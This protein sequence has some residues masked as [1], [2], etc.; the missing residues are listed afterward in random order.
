MTPI[1]GF[2]R[3]SALRYLSGMLL[4]EVRRPAYSR[5]EIVSDAVVHA[6]GVGLAVLAVPALVTAAALTRGDLPAVLGVTVYGAALIAMLTFSALYNLIPHPDWSRILQR[7]DHSAIYVKIAGTFTAL[8]LLAGQHLWLIGVL[9]SAATAGVSLKLWAPHGFRRIGLGLYL[10]MGW[11]GAVLGWGVFAALPLGSVVLIAAGGGIYT[12][13]VL[14]YLWEKLPH[15]MAIWHVFVLLGSLA[16][17]GGVT[18]A[19]V[20]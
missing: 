19:I 9:W 4:H 20:A 11:I 10:G 12:T 16:V 14:F 13:G 5:A 18:V 7:L 17:Y 15:H 8:A 3:R 2:G 6:L 1:N